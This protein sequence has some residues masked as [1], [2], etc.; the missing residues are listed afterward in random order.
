MHPSEVNR[1]IRDDTWPSSLPEWAYTETSS[2]HLA[3]NMRTGEVWYRW[4]SDQLY[5]PMREPSHAMR[6]VSHTTPDSIMAL[7]LY[8]GIIIAAVVAICIGISCAMM[9]LGGL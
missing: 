6:S 9:Y 3:T 5:H 7:I 2:D 4:E 1:R 8:A